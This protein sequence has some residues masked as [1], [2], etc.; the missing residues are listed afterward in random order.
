MLELSAIR[1]TI[2][3]GF[4]RCLFASGYE[5]RARHAAVPRLIGSAE[6][7]VWGFDEHSEDLARPQTTRISEASVLNP[8]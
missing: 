5:Q 6:V 8:R 1:R 2:P 3:T 7:V 4:D